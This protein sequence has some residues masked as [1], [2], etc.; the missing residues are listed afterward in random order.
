MQVLFEAQLKG[1]AHSADDALGEALAALQDVAGWGS[2][3]DTASV[4]P[5][6]WHTLHRAPLP[7][8]LGLT[9][10]V[11]GV[12]SDIGHIIRHVL[13]REGAGGRGQLDL[14]G[15]TGPDSWLS[16]SRKAGNRGAQAHPPSPL[17]CHRPTRRRWT[18]CGGWQ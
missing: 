11:N 8:P 4:W 10:L 13:G 7:H 3:G 14:P 17:P 12:L 18:A 5:G 2:F 1:L 16:I 6:S 9:S 15:P